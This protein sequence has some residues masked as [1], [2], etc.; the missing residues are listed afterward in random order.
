MP[1]RLFCLHARSSFTTTNKASNEVFAS[2]SMLSP[3]HDPIKSFIPL[4][5]FLRSFSYSAKIN[6]SLAAKIISLFLEVEVITFSNHGKI[7]F[8][9]SHILLFSAYLNHLPN[10]N[11][12][13][14]F[15]CSFI[16]FAFC[17]NALHN[18][19]SGTTSNNFPSKYS[20][21]Y[22]PPS[23]VFFISALLAIVFIL[24]FGSGLSSNS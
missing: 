24:P 2:V 6:A 21:L 12:A 9:S 15:M 5:P 11:S 17:M 7:A 10:K 4:F 22:P 1:L 20:S 19:P 16:S 8:G 3:Y 13:H 18:G 14:K 23:A